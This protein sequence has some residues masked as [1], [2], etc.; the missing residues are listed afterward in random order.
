M[1]FADADLLHV[2]ESLYMEEA[3]GA[4]WT[5][6]YGKGSVRRYPEYLNP[7]KGCPA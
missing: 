5:C 7:A 1:S 6:R 2:G 3:L 4:C